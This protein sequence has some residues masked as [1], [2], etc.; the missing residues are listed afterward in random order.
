MAVRCSNSPDRLDVVHYKREQ[1][2][3]FA[4]AFQ[5]VWCET[6]EISPLELAVD[7]VADP[8]DE[9]HLYRLRRR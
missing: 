9:T 2:A 6:I 3:A 5:M 1:A 4:P 7:A 8:V